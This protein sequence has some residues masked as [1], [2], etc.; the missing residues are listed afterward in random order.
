MSDLVTSVAAYVNAGL[1]VIALTGKR[2]NTHFHVE[3]DYENSIHGTIETPEDFADLYG[4]FGHETTTGVAILIPPNVLVADV[5]TEEA[6]TLFMSLAGGEMPDVPVA[7]TMNGL[8]VW[9]LAP[10]ADQS[11]WL[12]GRTLLFKGL[13][14]YVVA[15]PSAHP[16]GGVYTWLNPVVEDGRIVS[17]DYMP[18]LMKEWLDAV[19]AVEVRR[20]VP[21]TPPFIPRLIITPTGIRTEQVEMDPIDGLCHAIIEAADGNQNNTI[22]WAAMTAQEEGVPFEVAMDRLL[23]AAV[24]GGHPRARAK[25]TIKGVYTRRRAK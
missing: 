20:D 9:F 12:G 23:A 3:W 2:P 5:D 11:R 17:M 7:K 18:D 21:Y 13:G 25:Q 1:H 10:G 19:E 24:E 4:I 14:G 16:D 6:A 8:H 15:P 22:A